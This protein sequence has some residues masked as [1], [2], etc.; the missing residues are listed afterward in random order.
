MALIK[1]YKNEEGLLKRFTIEVDDD[2][3]N[4]RSEFDNITHMYLWWNKY[5]LGD[6]NGG[7]VPSLVMREIFY[8]IDPDFD[9]ADM[10]VDQLIVKLQ[11]DYTEQ[12]KILPCF[13]LEHSG[14]AI[15]CAPFDNKWDSGLAGFIYI[16]RSEA[17]EAGIVWSDARTNILSDVDVYNMYL[18]GQV[19]MF[20][21]DDDNGYTGGYYSDKI[22]DALVEEIAAEVG[23]KDVRLYDESEVDIEI[24]EKITLKPGVE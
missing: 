14:I 19:Y 5:N 3:P 15:S 18:S 20:D 17:D 23:L 22:G 6:N 10:T 21:A 8:K 16:L 4:P 9:P 24:V 12:I 11:S 2:P 7:D 1:Y 13:V